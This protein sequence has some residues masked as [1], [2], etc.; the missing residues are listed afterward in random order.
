MEFRKREKQRIEPL[1]S[2]LFSAEASEPGRYIGDRRNFCLLQLLQPFQLIRLRPLRR[3]FPPYRGLGGVVHTVHPVQRNGRP[4]LVRNIAFHRCIRATAGSAHHPTLSGWGVGYTGPRIAG[5]GQQGG[6]C[7]GS[8]RTGFQITV[9]WRYAAA[10]GAVGRGGGAVGRH[11]HAR[12]AGTGRCCSGRFPDTA[13]PSDI[14]APAGH[15]RPRT[16]HPV[17]RPETNRRRSKPPGH[18]SPLLRI[19]PIDRPKNEIVLLLRP[20]SA[21]MPPFTSLQTRK[22]LRSRPSPPPNHSTWLE[23]TKQKHGFSRS[24]TKILFVASLPQVSTTIGTGVHSPEYAA[25][26]RKAEVDTR[27]PFRTTRQNNEWRKE[28]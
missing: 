19:V 26:G 24:K 22:S 25:R 12:R 11:L 13:R 15:D 9:R 28:Q 8:C 27:R 10:R 7:D 3:R 21:S 16:A 5:A 6:S 2:N 18:S 1:K 17:D 23:R 4:S 20:R 14:T